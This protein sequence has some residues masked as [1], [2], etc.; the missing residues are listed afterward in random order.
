MCDTCCCQDN[1]YYCKPKVNVAKFGIRHYAGEVTYQVD[2][3]LEKNRDTFRDDILKMLKESR[4]VGL[5]WREGHGTGLGWLGSSVFPSTCLCSPV[6]DSVP[7]YL[8]LFPLL[9][10]ARS[11]FVYDLFEHMALSD[12]GQGPG[13]G[14]IGRRMSLK[15]KGARKKATVSSQFK[16]SLHSLMT[17][18]GQSNPYFVRCIKPNMM[19]VSPPPRAASAALSCVQWGRCSTQGAVEQCIWL[20]STSVCLSVHL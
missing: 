6:L 4:W 7:Q 12:T 13:G 18:L 1:P 15:R 17:I 3:L 9:P 20:L 14:G 10:A 11:E 2:G 5:G 16:D 8:S 19:K